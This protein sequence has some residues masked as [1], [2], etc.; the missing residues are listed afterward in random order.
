M[1]GLAVVDRNP[2]SVS[3]ECSI[4]LFGC[5]AFMLC[6]WV[7]YLKLLFRLKHEFLAFALIFSSLEN[8]SLGF[9]FVITMFNEKESAKFRLRKRNYPKNKPP[10]I[11]EVQM[12][13]A[14]ECILPFDKWNPQMT[15]E[16]K[17]LRM[18]GERKFE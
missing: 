3:L 6:E 9:K 1:F 7:L 13:K 15:R 10:K 16:S 12:I 18:I 5:I 17:S 14:K 8:G 2:Y 11:I 4:A